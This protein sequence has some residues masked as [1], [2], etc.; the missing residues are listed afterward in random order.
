LVAAAALHTDGQ[1]VT[2]SALAATT[3]V[4]PLVFSGLGRLWAECVFHLPDIPVAL[5]GPADSSPCS[6]CCIC[7]RS[8]PNASTTAA[9]SWWAFGFDR[10]P[11]TGVSSVYEAEYPRATPPGCDRSAGSSSSEMWAKAAISAPK[12]TPGMPAGPSKRSQRLIFDLS[13]PHSAAHRKFR[14]CACDAPARNVP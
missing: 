10:Q 9:E 2:C 6:P 4:C 7:C 5:A 1:C 8:A 12:K 13:N 11:F 14:L 3:G